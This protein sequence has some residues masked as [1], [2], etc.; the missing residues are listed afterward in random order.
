M[1]GKRLTRRGFLRVAAL[2]A[3]STALAA[4]APR[5]VKETVIVEKPVEKVVEKVV[6]ATPAAPEEM[7][8]EVRATQPE[9]ENA[10]KQ[11][12]AIFEQEH[13]GVKIEMFSV[14]EDQVAAYEAKIA[15]GWIPAMDRVFEVNQD[16][17][18]NFVNL[19]GDAIDFEWFDR[20][21][22]DVRNAW[23]EK[24]G[25]PGVYTLDFYQG[26][27]FT[28]QYH[29]DLMEKAGLNPRSDVETWDDLKRFLDE[30]TK[31]AAAQD[32]VDNFWDEAF[33]TW[34]F[35]VNLMDTIPLAFADGQRDRQRQCFLG[36]IPF[37]GSNSPYRH[38]FEFFKEAHDKGWLPENWWLREWESDM[39]ANYIAKKSV[40]MLH[41]PWTWDKMLAADPS[42]QQLGLPAT[43]PA[44][45]QTQWMQS[46]GRLA[47][48]EGSCLWQGVQL[49][50]EWDMIQ[51]AFNWWHSPKVVKMRAEVEG[52][53]IVY[54][55]DEPVELEGAQWLGVTKDIGASG[56]VFEDVSYETGQVGEDAVARYLKEGA[57]GVWDW[58]SGKLGEVFGDV[59]QEKITVQE[60]LDWVQKNWEESY[61]MG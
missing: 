61:D 25:A 4:C 37:N 19:D 43:P 8:L 1:E 22:Y 11:I 49:K 17:Y 18:Q 9:Y 6:T 41:G 10:E 39:E 26:F 24:Y 5:V 21:E 28:W 36:E 59:M 57:T 42:A 53:P 54:T 14:N 20:W 3:A 31:W 2:G 44:E 27:V 30:G 60:A 38:T 55:T 45:G 13:P 29:A 40:M 12:W 47:I 58:E 7:V 48:Y 23:S 16:N 35:G 51:K 50:P 34:V 46:M 52:R 56:G 32:D 33:H 15:G